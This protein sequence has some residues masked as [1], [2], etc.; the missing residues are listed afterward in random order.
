LLSD[1]YQL[2]RSCKRIGLFDSGVGGLSVLRKLT[3]LS[4]LPASAE[5]TVSKVFVYLGDTARFP[6]GNRTASEIIVFVNQ[7]IHWLVDQGVDGI[8][9]A[10]NTSNAL[11]L[12]VA[13]EISPV[14]IFDIIGPT[15]S[16]L[17][18][19]DQKVG[20]LS[21]KS[22]STSRAYSKA[23]AAINPTMEVVEIGCPDL[24][25]LVE[26]GKIF[27]STTKEALRPYVDTLL[28]ADV[29]ALVL[30]CTHFPFLSGPLRELIDQ[31]IAIVDPADI[32]VGQ[33][34]TEADAT[35]GELNQDN[36]YKIFVTGDRHQFEQTA[37]M[38]LGYPIATSI[39]LTLDELCSSHS[40][41]KVKERE[42]VSIADVETTK[43]NSS[44]NE[45]LVALSSVGNS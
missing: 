12:D 15:A 29:K 18:S 23:I 44:P 19:L 8:V 21:T 28:R 22:T 16:Y 30:G 32:L 25:P 45:S 35:M 14:P 4:S 34:N 10:C 24:V 26:N 3:N 13:R 9:I 43:P 7:I 20:I 5:T 37:K 36:H 2:L 41:R 31:Q 11:A 39:S 6:Y 1:H 27:H 42:A 17:A 33:L 38:C 40:N